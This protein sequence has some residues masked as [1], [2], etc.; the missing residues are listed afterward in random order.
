MTGYTVHVGRPEARWLAGLR[1]PLSR[2]GYFGTRL[3]PGITDCGDGCVRFDEAALLALAGLPA[4]EDGRV[5]WE[6]DDTPVLWFG[7]DRHTVKRDGD[8]VRGAFRP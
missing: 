1:G 6:G 3:A 2:D 8:S 4:D 5:T 7:R